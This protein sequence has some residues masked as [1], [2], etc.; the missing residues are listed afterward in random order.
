MVLSL[1][2]EDYEQTLL[3]VFLGQC[4][5]HKLAARTTGKCAVCL[6]KRTSAVNAAGNIR[7]IGLPKPLG[8]KELCKEDGPEIIQGTAAISGSDVHV[9]KHGSQEV[10]HNDSNKYEMRRK[11]E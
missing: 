10:C 2:R 3:D 4:Y 6:V 5:G 1:H 11:R 9:D 7:A 8:I